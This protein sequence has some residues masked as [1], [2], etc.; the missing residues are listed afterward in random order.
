[1]KKYP[2]WIDVNG[3]AYFLV[4]NDM[5]IYADPNTGCMVYRNGDPYIDGPLP[6]GA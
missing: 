2:Y 5:G 3:V 4:D 1:M 6:S